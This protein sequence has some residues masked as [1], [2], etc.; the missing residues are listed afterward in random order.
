MID[1]G[2]GVPSHPSIELCWD[3]NKIIRFPQV[4]QLLEFLRK[5]A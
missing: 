5:I 2:M 1:P 3:Q 4:D